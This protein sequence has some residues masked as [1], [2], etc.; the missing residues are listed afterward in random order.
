MPYDD[1]DDG[2]DDVDNVNEDANSGDTGNSADNNKIKKCSAHAEN[3]RSSSDA[4]Y[5]RSY[6]DFIA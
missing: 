2:C 6:Q 1:D 5:S 3:T 4:D